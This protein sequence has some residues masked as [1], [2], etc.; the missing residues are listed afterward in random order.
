MWS[1]NTEKLC[2]DFRKPCVKDQCIAYGKL[3][4]EKPGPDGIEVSDMYGCTKYELSHLVQRDIAQRTYQLCRT[5]E[6]ARNEIVKS[7]DFLRQD[8]A[9]AMVTAAQTRLLRF[10]GSIVDVDK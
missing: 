3:L 9:R 4:V 7:N 8:I 1:R 2:P 10:D 6:S 5:V